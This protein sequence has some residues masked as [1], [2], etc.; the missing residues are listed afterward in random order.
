MSY[1]QVK[2]YQEMGDFVVAYNIAKKDWEC[3]PDSKRTKDT[4][5]WANV[6][7]MKSFA[8]AYGKHRFMMCLDELTTIGVNDNDEKL[9][10]AV[11]YA[12]RDI[13]AD[14]FRMQWFSEDFGDTI[15]DVIMP[16]P[17]PKPSDSY[18]AMLGAFIELGALWPRL[19]DFIDWWDR[20]NFT[21]F[22]KRR[23]PLNGRLVS[24]EERVEEAYKKALT[25]KK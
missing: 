12:V 6:R 3:S 10:G 17:L 8:R 16:L 25:W 11:A 4:L 14:S 1:K 5:A 2:Y 9:W 15:F 19:A 20:A 21:P 13:V 22:D 24:F 7:L 18:S 23:Y